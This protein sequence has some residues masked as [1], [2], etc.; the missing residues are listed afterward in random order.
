ME[1]ARPGAKKGEEGEV[2]PGLKGKGSQARPKSKGRQNWSFQAPPYRENG[3]AKME[4]G[5]P[6][7]IQKDRPGQ[8]ERTGPA[9]RKGR[10][11]G[12]A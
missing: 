3:P 9:K 5:G 8:K 1:K 7:P 2:R 12:Q 10:G 4:R 6:G 11:M